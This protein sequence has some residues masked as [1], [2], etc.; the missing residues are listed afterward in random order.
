[1]KATKTV[2]IEGKEIVLSRCLVKDL[3]S[4]SN[5]DLKKYFEENADISILML[6]SIEYIEVFARKYTNLS[7]E[8]LEY[9]DV[10]ALWALFQEWLAFNGISVD[11]IK[12]NFLPL[13]LSLQ[14]QKAK[15]LTKKPKEEKA[16]SQQIPT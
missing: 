14:A 1:M 16:Y 5:F 3:K 6:Q 15:H 4:L 13:S 2:T 10:V 11:W 8:E 9:L 7:P 12:K